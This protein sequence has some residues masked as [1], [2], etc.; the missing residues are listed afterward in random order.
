MRHNALGIVRHVRVPRVDVRY[1][2]SGNLLGDLESVRLEL[3]QPRR[4]VDDQRAK[5]FELESEAPD[6]VLLSGVDFKQGSVV[7]ENNDSTAIV[8]KD[9]A[10]QVDHTLLDRHHLLD[11]VPA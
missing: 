3:P 5:A 6:G 8:A 2:S 4:R 7:L 1:P 11:E 9:V 10:K